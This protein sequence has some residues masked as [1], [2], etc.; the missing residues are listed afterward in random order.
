M[1]WRSTEIMFL[2][3]VLAAAIGGCSSPS[4][5]NQSCTPGAKQCTAD[6]KG[7]QICNAAGTGYTTAHCLSTCSNNSC[8]RSISAQLK[9]KKTYKVA[10][11]GTPTA[12]PPAIQFIKAQL[13]GQQ[14]LRAERSPPFARALAKEFKLLGGPMK[15]PRPSQSP[16]GAQPQPD[17]GILRA[18]DYYAADVAVFAYDESQGTFVDSQYLD[19]A[20]GYYDVYAG[21]N[22]TVS[23]WY[24]TYANNAATIICPQDYGFDYNIPPGSTDVSYTYDAYFSADPGPNAGY[25]AQSTSQAGYYSLSWTD[26]ASG[27]QKTVYAYIMADGNYAADGSYY[28]LWDDGTCSQGSH[29]YI[30]FDATGNYFSI[31]GVD[32]PFGMSGTTSQPGYFN[33]QA[34]WDVVGDDGYTYEVLAQVS[35]LSQAP[36][37]VCPAQAIVVPANPVTCPLG[38]SLDATFG[39]CTVDGTLD[40]NTGIGVSC[41]LAADGTAIAVCAPGC[42]LQG[43]GLCYDSLNEVCL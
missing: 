20:T 26:A 21:D 33:G 17:P 19:P 38:C 31:N 42:V 14:A 28:F 39:I 37:Q 7:L 16:P 3:G 4:T 36:A 18:Q 30:S 5:N 11:T 29:I 24:G 23:L 34:R 12:A 8:G 40:A 2:G 32:A 6:N 27:A 43:D 1:M 9:L 10:A 25:V 15:A 41:G 13:R 35:Y 22:S